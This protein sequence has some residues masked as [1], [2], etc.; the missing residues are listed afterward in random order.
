M[1]QVTKPARNGLARVKLVLTIVV[2]SVGSLLALSQVDGRSTYRGAAK[3]QVEMLA[4]A[5]D[6][7]VL[8]I[9]SCPTT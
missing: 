5:V 3:S 2:F 6:M 1:S 7:Y 9:G 8:A 4:G